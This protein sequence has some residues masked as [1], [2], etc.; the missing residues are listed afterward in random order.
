MPSYHSQS[1]LKKLIRRSKSHSEWNLI[2][3][4]SI[5]AIAMLVAALLIVIRWITSL[6]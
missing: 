4:Y 1:K 2:F 5:P 6:V 3:I